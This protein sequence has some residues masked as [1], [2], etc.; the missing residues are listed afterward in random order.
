MFR[1]RPCFSWDRSIGTDLGDIGSWPVHIHLAHESQQPTYTLHVLDYICEMHE[2]LLH[3]FV[4][5]WTAVCICHCC[6]VSRSKDSDAV[7]IPSGRTPNDCES[8]LDDWGYMDM[9]FSLGNQIR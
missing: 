6:G 4:P 1:C 8:L 3:F 5:R 2:R 7:N 9:S